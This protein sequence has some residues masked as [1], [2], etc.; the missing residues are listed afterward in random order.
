SLIFVLG[1]LAPPPPSGW[2]IYVRQP[3]DNIRMVFP[4]WPDLRDSSMTSARM[5]RA[6]AAVMR[7]TNARFG[8][9]HRNA[10]I[11]FAHPP[12][13]PSGASIDGS[14]PPSSNRSVGS[15]TAR[16]KHLSRSL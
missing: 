5:R 8:E 14:T 9:L 10:A 2:L 4:T 16:S 1:R 6:G 3:A 7:L 11:H 15:S 13:R 12:M